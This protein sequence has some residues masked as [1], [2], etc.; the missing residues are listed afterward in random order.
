MSNTAELTQFHEQ[1][2]HEDARRRGF[3]DI[4][5]GLQGDMNFAVMP[6]GIISG[7]HM[8][9]IHTDYFTVAKGRVMFRLVA[10]DGKEEKVVLSEH[11]RKTLIIQPGIWHGYKSLEPSVM[12][13]YIS[14]KFNEDDE[15]KKPTKP[16]EWE[17]EIK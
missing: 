4:I 14:Q 10:E 17:I 8:H 7:M 2:F 16:E 13:F 3:Y 15:F 5:P 1:R 12:V 11:S 6:A 9:K